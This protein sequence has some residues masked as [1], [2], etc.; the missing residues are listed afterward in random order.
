MEKIEDK[1]YLTLKKISLLNDFCIKK[2]NF[3]NDEYL[4]LDIFKFPEHQVWQTPEEF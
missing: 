4:I 3:M 1:K 2:R